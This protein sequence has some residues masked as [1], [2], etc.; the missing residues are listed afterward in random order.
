MYVEN[1]SETFS[2]LNIAIS[3]KMESSLSP[4]IWIFCRLDHMPL[5]SLARFLTISL[6]LQMSQSEKQD[7]VQRHYRLQEEAPAI[8]KRESGG[9]KGPEF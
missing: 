2:V 1:S 9:V 5:Q 8:V 7:C 3:Q 4:G 6:R